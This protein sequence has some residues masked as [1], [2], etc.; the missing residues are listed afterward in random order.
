MPKKSHQSTEEVFISAEDADL[1]DLF[2]IRRS[3]NPD[4]SLRYVQ[5]LGNATEIEAFARNEKVVV[6]D[7]MSHNQRAFSL[8]RLI[9][10]RIL[11]RPLLPEELVTMKNGKVGD[12]RRENLELTSRSEVAQR[13]RSG[14]WSETGAKYVYPGEAGRYYANV[15]GSY[16]GIYNTVDQASAAVK[17]YFDFLES[18]MDEKEA[19]RRV[20][21][22]SRNS[23]KINIA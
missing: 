9:M 18:G 21:G 3:Y 16:L 7:D 23:G 20:K 14:S 13:E 10:Q 19:A 11:N 2:L 5:V 15:N 12:C 1:I 17:Q 22:R 4:G 8:P 6:R